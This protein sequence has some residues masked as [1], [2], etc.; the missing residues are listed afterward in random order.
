MAPQKS[1]GYKKKMKIA[2]VGHSYINRMPKIF[3]TRATIRKFCYGG[4]HAS[5][6]PDSDQ[7]LDLQEF[8]PDIIY[9]Q[10]GGNDINRHSDPEIIFQDILGLVWQWNYGRRNI[11]IL[12]GEIEKRTKPRGM[13]I[14]QYDSQR[15]YL[16]DLLEEEFG[17]KF[18]RFSFVMNHYL[19]SDGVHL[20]EE[21]SYRFSKDIRTHLK[22]YLK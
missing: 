14:N 18:V 6:F 17:D 13:T 16:N 2:I 8:D 19:S 21:G 9:L 11:P 7:F 5:S 20:T 12:V 10:I 15:R 22:Q 4:A 3:F 1:Y